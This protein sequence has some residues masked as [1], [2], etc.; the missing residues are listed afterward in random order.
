MEMETSGLVGGDGVTPRLTGC[1]RSLQTPG[2]SRSFLILSFSIDCLMQLY[3]LLIHNKSI[4]WEGDSL[5][6]H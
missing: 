6:F 1:I 2:S 4:F 3:C 5:C